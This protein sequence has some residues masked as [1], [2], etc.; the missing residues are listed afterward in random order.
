MGTCGFYFSCFGSRT[1]FGFPLLLICLKGS[2][3]FILSLLLFNNKTEKLHTVCHD[4]CASWLSLTV[5]VTAVQ[6]SNIPHSQ[7]SREEYGCSPKRASLCWV[8][9]FMRKMGG[10]VLFT[11]SFPVL[12]SCPNSSRQS[13]SK[14]IG[15][16]KPSS[17][18]MLCSA[19]KEGSCLYLALLCSPACA[20]A[21]RRGWISE[22]GVFILEQNPSLLPWALSNVAITALRQI[23]SS[24]GD[25]TLIIMLLPEGA[26]TCKPLCK[27]ELLFLKNIQDHSTWF[28]QCYKIR[29][30][31]K[32]NS[33]KYLQHNSLMHLW[34]YSQSA[35]ECGLT[36][37][38][39]LFLFF[40]NSL[41]LVFLSYI[42]PVSLFWLFTGQQP[43]L[44]AKS[45]ALREPV[46][47]RKQPRR[48]L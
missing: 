42:I 15:V 31:M 40:A 22:G 14:V 26:H 3:A 23:F 41:A 5:S 19:R 27:V 12:K 44:W 7:V 11:V 35:L 28:L 13:W 21:V 38:E 20:K 32:I 43:L 39:A 10:W 33:F 25:Y 6:G 45:W 37:Q 30:K 24:L 1:A 17:F 16:K 2:Q 9:Y 36:F 46:H 8:C 47:N 29:P 34:K 18:S 4:A 48:S